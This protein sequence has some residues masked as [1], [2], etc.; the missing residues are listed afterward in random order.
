MSESTGGTRAAPLKGDVEGRV[1]GQGSGGK[2]PASVTAVTPLSFLLRFVFKFDASFR[3]PTP[4]LHC[5]PPAHLRDLQLGWRAQR[6]EG[7][8]DP[9]SSPGGL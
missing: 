9:L 8:G 5:C 2:T 3:T 1:P 4:H 7:P 6:K